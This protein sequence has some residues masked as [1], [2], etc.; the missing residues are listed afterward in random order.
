V[1]QNDIKNLPRNDQAV[2]GL[3]ILAFIASF[4]PFY[5]V[6]VNVGGFKGSSSISTWHSYAVLGIL[7]VLAATILAAAQVFA[8]SSLPSMPVSANFLVAGLA[9]LGTLLIIIRGFTY[10]SAS[11]PGAS[12]GLKWGFY[13][14]MI[15]C[16]AQV[17]F[18]VMRLRE[19][20]EAMPWESRGSAAPP[21][22]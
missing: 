14:V 6:T 15:V 22:A 13:V 1:D 20:G 8:G 10:D 4:F 18:A 2:I 11:A 21:A 3:G 9:A 17:A 7:L 5:G 19:S 12:V 16:L